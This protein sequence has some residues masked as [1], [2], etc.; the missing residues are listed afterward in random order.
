M[1]L[2]FTIVLI[3]NVII[4]QAQM[5]FL[6]P[7]PGSS[8]HNPSRNIVIRPG[9]LIDVQSVLPSYFTV[10]GSFSGK[11]DINAVLALDQ[12]TINLNPVQPFAYAETV[13]VKMKPGVRQLNGSIYPDYSFIF[14]IRPDSAKLI[15]FPVNIKEDENS[16]TRSISSE[17]EHK[18]RGLG[19][20]F[21]ILVNTNP[22]PGQVFF[23]NDAFDQKLWI[24]Q[25]NGDSV[26]QRSSPDVGWDWKV[27]HNGYL[28]AHDSAGTGFF[29]MFDSNYLKIDSFTTIN[30]YKTGNHDFQI[31][32]DGH[33]F[34]QATDPQLMDL[35][36][37]DT[38]YQSNA[39]VT[40]NVI[41]EFDSN[42]NLIFEWRTWDHMSILET[43]NESLGNKNV[44]PFHLNSIDQDTDG[45]IIVS[46]RAM[47][48]VDK[49]DV[50]TGDFIWRLGGL[51]NE[52]TFIN[53]S[54]KFNTQHDV[55][56]IP[57]GHI[58]MF[59]NNNTLIPNTSF[60]KEYAL[61]EVNKTATLVWSYKH[62]PIDGNE[63]SSNAKGNVQRL[64]NGNT[65]INWGLF[66][67]T[68]NFPNI[69]EVDSNNNIVWELR[70]HEAENI[71]R[72]F[73]FLW[74]PCSRPSYSALKI[75]DTT[76]ISAVVIWNQ[77]TN[78]VKYNIQYRPQ[79]STEWISKIVSG[80]LLID[81]LT[82][83]VPNTVYEWQ[84]QSWCDDSGINQS[85][86]TTVRTFS[87]L[88]PTGIKEIPTQAL[89][90]FPNPSS[91][92]INIEW[93]PNTRITENDKIQ[94]L[95]L[96]G[97]EVKSIKVPQAN[98][99]I[100]TGIESLP[101]GIYMVRI[102]SGSEIMEGRLLKE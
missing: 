18:D 8:L 12:K 28:T 27:N 74:N 33:Y 55:R 60:A 64:E 88:L 66:N 39:T 77:A 48:Q 65:L 16:A 35:T 23:S 62:P 56:R 26:F 90:I 91:G 43:I 86:F 53:D 68:H 29:D 101:V 76:A 20:D 41:Q 98:N 49:I 93:T 71:Y 54:L 36:V 2:Y 21:D 84:I 96:L 87:T 45:N 24:I 17:E 59:D 42:K 69:T 85:G 97:Q 11:H 10:S 51:Y 37:Y 61:D 82:G 19:T 72:A 75:I 1:K 67:S 6:S 63:I 32:A 46:W 102:T 52:F 7:V 95:N 25:S 100:T 99:H 92:R 5:Q 44:R 73:R 4:T 70:Y 80:E 81:T 34:M 50:S 58:T 78:A 89:K 40:G 38:S 13:T 83:L 47:D 57:N 94:I 14:S 30:G 79:G 15:D 31:F 9:D 3:F 22:A